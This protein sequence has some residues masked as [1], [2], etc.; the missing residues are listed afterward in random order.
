VYEY[1]LF[2]Q[3][4]FLRAWDNMTPPQYGLLL[5]TIAVVGYLA[6]KHGAAGH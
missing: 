4:Y 6:M 1:V 3:K 2:Y 5:I